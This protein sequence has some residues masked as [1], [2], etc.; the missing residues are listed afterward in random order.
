[1]PGRALRSP[2]IQ[3]VEAGTQPKISRCIHCLAPC[4]PKASPYCISRALIDARNGDWENGLFFCGAN[5]GEVNR[6]STVQAQMD[7]IMDEWRNV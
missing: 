6:L 5:A 2:L 3:R 7:Q 1:M 4:D